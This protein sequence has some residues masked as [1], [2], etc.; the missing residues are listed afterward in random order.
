MALEIFHALRADVVVLHRALI[1]VRGRI[2]YRCV[3][4]PLYIEHSSKTHL[5]LICRRVCQ[6]AF[7][8]HHTLTQTDCSLAIIMGRLKQKGKSGA[9]KAYITRTAAVRK[10]QCSLADFRRLCILKGMCMA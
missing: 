3:V 2:G 4:H 9:A 8:C 6:R 10:L 7:V 5:I 1:L